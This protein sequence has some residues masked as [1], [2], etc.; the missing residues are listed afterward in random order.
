MFLLTWVSLKTVNL[1]QNQPS[2]PSRLTNLTLINTTE[3]NKALSEISQMHSGNITLTNAYILSYANGNNW[4][5]VWIS[6]SKSEKEAESSKRRMSESLQNNYMFSPPELIKVSDTKV[7]KTT[8]REN[9]T[10]YFYSSGSSVIWIG[11]NLNPSKAKLLLKEGIYKFKL[12][13]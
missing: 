10:H 2:F 3:G 5:K 8:D 13:L 6:V 7:F 12:S 1:S 4:A 9:Q 11:T